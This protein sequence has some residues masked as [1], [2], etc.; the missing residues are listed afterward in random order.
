MYIALVANL[1][2]EGLSYYPASTPYDITT[3]STDLTRVI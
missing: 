1:F 2:L 3:T